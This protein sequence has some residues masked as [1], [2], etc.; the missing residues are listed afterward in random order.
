MP[1]IKGICNEGKTWWMTQK[2]YWSERPAYAHNFT[3][4]VANLR[5]A[6]ADRRNAFAKSS[7]IIV[8]LIVES[9]SHE[10]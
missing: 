1:F 2:G 4:R 9:L 8:P 3:P 10:T 5:K 7:D 6:E